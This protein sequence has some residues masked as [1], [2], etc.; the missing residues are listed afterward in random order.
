M[1][2]QGILIRRMDQIEPKHAN[3]HENFEYK[4]YAVTERK[5]TDHIY[6]AFYE[7]PPGKA[8]YPYHY[9]M[10]NEE[11]FYIIRGNGTLR[12]P[13]GDREITAGDLVVCATGDK[14]AHK[15]INTSETE[16]LVYLDVDAARAVDVCGYPD[17]NKV[18][19]NSGGQRNLFFKEDSNVDYYMDE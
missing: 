16:T 17:S 14:S 15:I 1:D 7:I 10:A 2:A 11:V 8:N 13:E 5:A 18:G 3:V 6:A 9:H 4:K 12:T 19:L